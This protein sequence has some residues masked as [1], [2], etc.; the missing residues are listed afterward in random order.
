VMDSAGIIPEEDLQEVEATDTDKPDQAEEIS[1]ES[2]QR[3]SVFEDF[4]EGLDL[5]QEGG[6]GE[7]EPK[8]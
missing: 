3:L 4:L 2:E 7:D 5:D 6:E 1:E 8:E